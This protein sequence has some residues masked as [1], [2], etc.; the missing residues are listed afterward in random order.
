MGLP[1][2]PGGK[3]RID[4]LLQ[5]RLRRGTEQ[6]AHNRLNRDSIHTDDGN[7]AGPSIG[8]MSAIYNR[9]RN[10]SYNMLYTNI[11]NIIYVY[12]I[13]IML[14]RLFTTSKPGASVSGCLRRVIIL[15][16]DVFYEIAS[17]SS[18]YE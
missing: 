12:Y 17:F 4:Q 11:S 18:F 8:N 9:Y 5:A 14:C 1:P 13:K 2:G 10:I 15:K 7:I 16:N 3:S 6:G